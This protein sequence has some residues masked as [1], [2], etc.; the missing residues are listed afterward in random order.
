LEK[1][2]ASAKNILNSQY[3][4]AVYSGAVG[5]AVDFL[6]GLLAEFHIDVSAGLQTKT[7]ILAM[8]LTALLVKNREKEAEGDTGQR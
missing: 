3:N 4:K 8:A 5:A 1:V 6:F 7:L 2:K